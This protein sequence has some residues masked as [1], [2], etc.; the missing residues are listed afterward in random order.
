MNQSS[1]SAFRNPNSAI[2]LTALLVALYLLSLWLFARLVS[3]ERTTRGL[4]L[5]LFFVNLLLVYTHYYGWLVVACEAAFL[6]FRDR[7]K[8][9]LMLPASVALAL[10]FV[11]WVAAC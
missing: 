8:L 10:L 7:R 5:A 4:F 2:V 6:S 1:Q 11:P 3:R 9:R